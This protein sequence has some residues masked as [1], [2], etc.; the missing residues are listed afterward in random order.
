MSDSRCI[1][2]T[3]PEFE[4]IMQLLHEADDRVDQN[5]NPAFELHDD[6]Q[7][8]WFRNEDEWGWPDEPTDLD[9][10]LSGR[11]FKV[12]EDDFFD[13]GV[14]AREMRRQASGSQLERPF[15]DSDVRTGSLA[16]DRRTERLM[17]GTATA[18]V[19]NDPI[20]W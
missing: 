10:D 3:E 6:L 13:A 14:R 16:A 19:A 7:E 12:A 20:D 18:F 8:Q 15:A 5:G 17:R 2:L 4:L 1:K 11:T 9:D